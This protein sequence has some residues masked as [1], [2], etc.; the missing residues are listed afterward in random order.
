MTFRC[1]VL[2]PI[3]LA[4]I[5]AL[6]GVA[7]TGGSV[8]GTVAD[9]SGGVIPGVLV[10]ARNAETG[11]EQKTVTNGEGFFGFPS[12]PEGRYAAEISHSGFLPYKAE[13][14]VDSNAALRVDIRLIVGAQTNAVT[15]TE[16]PAQVET[17]STQMGELIAARKMASI[18]VNGR[19]YT[20]LL[21]LQPGVVPASSQQPN[22]VVMSGCTSAPPS[23][24]L[25]PG[26]LSVSGQRETANGFTV[27]GSSAQEDFNMGAAIVP[28]LDSIQEFRVLTN[29]F[30]AEYGNF[31]GGQVLVTTKSGTN[32]LHG[33][34][35]EFL[36]NT[37][38]DARNYFRHR[39]RPIRPQSVRR[40]A[41]RPDPQGQALLLRRLSGHAHDTRRGDG[42]DLGSLA[43]RTAPAISRTSPVRSRARSTG[44]IGRTCFPQK[45]G[46]AV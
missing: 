33:S 36:R 23:G 38:L 13:V 7:G 25:N 39:A 14:R 24:D 37:D 11:M 45:L 1:A 31:S 22:A 35:F 28:N 16:A 19:S 43:G 29:N 10:A 42:P 41:G 34:A 26:N 44:S 46:Y 30:D 4:L 20:D 18:P 40:H 2:L 6:P 32:E 17:A 15:V 5:A 3:L 27:N 12:L 21:A 8:A 9:P